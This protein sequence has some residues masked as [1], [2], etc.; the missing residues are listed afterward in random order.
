MAFNPLVCTPTMSE[1]ELVA[2]MQGVSFVDPDLESRLTAVKD[3]QT[4]LKTFDAQRGWTGPSGTAASLLVEQMTGNAVKIQTALDDMKQNL[5]DTATALQQMAAEAYNRLPS[6]TA[7]GW[8]ADTGRSLEDLTDGW[9]ILD[10]GEALARAEEQLAAEREMAA[11]DELK[12]IRE[13][14]VTSA[15]SAYGNTLTIVSRDGDPDYELPGVDVGGI[16]ASIP[17]VGSNSPV[18]NPPP[19]TGGVSP[20][21]P[22]VTTPEGPN[23]DPN[24]P[25]PWIW[26][27][28]DPEIPGTDP[29]IPIVDDPRV[30]IVDDPGVGQVPGGPG[31]GQVP[32]GPG[33]G[34]A[35][36]GPGGPSGLWGPG[37]GA[38]T[39]GAGAGGA[40]A[41]LGGRAVGGGALAGG[42]PS[43]PIGSTMYGRGLLGATNAP[44]GAAGTSNRGAMGT[45]AR[46]GA[47]GTAPRG[48]AAGSSTRGGA[49]GTSARGGAAGTSARGGAAGTSARGGAAGTSARGKAGA[50]GS[51]TS[52]GAVG[53]STGAM[54][55]RGQGRADDKRRGKTMQ[56]GPLGPDLE[57]EDDEFIPLSEGGRAGSRD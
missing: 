11:I 25:P 10:T 1:D 46:G 18:L 28:T 54:G 56:G 4:A 31:V 47:A 6:A 15:E 7:E 42:A 8:L 43:R 52:K 5:V 26:D 14:L 9:G 38:T 39:V 12:Q 17:G 34:V 35:S 19:G 57:I 36:P 50:A 16:D 13:E 21:G 49:L 45:S 27:P 23:D 53:R 32:G 2:H 33:P 29:D 30:P 44:N 48:G 51:G 37:G 24:Q 40:A 41:L 3:L 20:T 55:G 22:G